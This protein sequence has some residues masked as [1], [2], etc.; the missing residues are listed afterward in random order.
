MVERVGP[1]WPSPAVVFSLIVGQADDDPMALQLAQRDYVRPAM[2]C[3]PIDGER[4]WR[5]HEGE[6]LVDLHLR[7]MDVLGDGATLVRSDGIGQLF[8]AQ[9]MQFILMHADDFDIRRHYRQQAGLVL[10]A[11]RLEKTLHRIHHLGVLIGRVAT[12]RT[13]QGEGGENE[14]TKVHGGR[15]FGIG[16][17]D[18]RSVTQ[19]VALDAS[20]AISNHS[21]RVVLPAA[22]ARVLRA[23]FM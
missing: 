17:A 2:I 20:G 23:A 1:P 11:E 21:G 22:V 14:S 19:G 5:P 3:A 18:W 13:A 7:I 8:D 12:P 15:P 9:S 10:P 6:V 4:V 16:V